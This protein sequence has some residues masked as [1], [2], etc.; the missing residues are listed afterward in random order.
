MEKPFLKWVGGKTQILD[1]VLELFPKDMEQYHEP[2][3]GGGSVL[4]GLLSLRAKGEIRVG[5]VF[6]SDVN[7]GLISLYQ[8]IQSRVEE[9]LTL[10]Q[11]LFDGLDACTGTTV[12]RKDLTPDPSKETFYFSIRRRFN[13]VDRTTVEASAMF[14][15]LNKT[16]FRGVYR[17]GP[18]GFNVPYGNYKTVHLD[19]DHLRRVSRLIQ[20]VVFTAEPF[21]SSLSKVHGFVYVDPPYAPLNATSFVGYQASGFHLEDHQALFQLCKQKQFLMSN[22]D[23]ELVREAFVGYPMTVISCRRAI[24]S[25]NPETRTNELLIGVAP[26]SDAG[27][28]P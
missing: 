22:A 3:L 24:H 21:Q 20:G 12:N 23:V 28:P 6:A 15:F 8:N 2:F 19:A 1:H 9:V 4:L 7:L 25:K 11:G 13:E 14:L 26:P 16:C 27:A 10:A 18:N 5:Q 17:E